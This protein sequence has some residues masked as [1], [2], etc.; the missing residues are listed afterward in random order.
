M[1]IDIVSFARLKLN[2]ITD[3]DN[4]KTKNINNYTTTSANIA[5]ISY[6]KISH[7][8]KAFNTKIYYRIIK[9]IEK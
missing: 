7:E 6:N 4:I 2:Y 9:R 5:N 8:K 1:P 3:R